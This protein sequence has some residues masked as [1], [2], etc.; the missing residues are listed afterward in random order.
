MIHIDTLKK[1]KVSEITL[2]DTVIPWYPGERFQDF[3]GD[4]RMLKSLI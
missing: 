2:N 3:L 4:T 1:K